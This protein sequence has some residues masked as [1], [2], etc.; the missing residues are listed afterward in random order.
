MKAIFLDI[1]GVLQPFMQKRFDHTPLRRP[2]EDECVDEI[3][4]LAKRLDKELANGFCYY[5]YIGGDASYGEA[6]RKK[7]DLGAVYY[8]WDRKA[9][10]RLQRIIDTTGAKIILSSDWREFSLKVMYGLLDIYGLGKYLYGCTFFVPWTS[11]LAQELSYSEDIIYECRKDYYSCMNALTEGIGE[12]LHTYSDGQRKVVNTRVAE[13]L[14]YLDRHQEIT[15][16]VVIDDMNINNGLEGHFI[17][18][19]PSLPEESVQPCIDILQRTDG[20]YPLPASLQSEK[21]EQ[22]RQKWVDGKTYMSV[23]PSP[24]IHSLIILPNR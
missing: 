7:Y 5:D 4:E 23:S 17:E 24:A 10:A 6:V 3:A 8:D 20:P 16:F 22:W 11:E 9:V 19:Y 2:E 12:L 21:L 15:S 18:T 14:E 13:I 1:D